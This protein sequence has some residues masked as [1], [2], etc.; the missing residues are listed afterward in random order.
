MRICSSLLPAIR[1]ETTRPYTAMTARGSFS[2][3]RIRDRE[4]DFHLLP[5]ICKVSVCT[6]PRRSGMTHNDRNQRLDAR[7]LS[8]VLPYD[9]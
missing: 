3:A 8:Q 2:R 4:R 6:G 5:D 9:R 7:H 1:T